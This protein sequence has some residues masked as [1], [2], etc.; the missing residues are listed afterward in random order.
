MVRKSKGQLQNIKKQVKTYLLSSE[1]DNIDD[2]YK[3]FLICIAPEKMHD[4]IAHAAFFLT[5]GATMASEACMLGVP[6]LYIN[7]LQALGNINEQVKTFPLIA[8]QSADGDKILE[9]LYEKLE[10][11]ISNKKKQEIIN[12]IEKT[13]INP[14]AFLIWFIENYPESAKIMKE[15]P[16]YQYNFK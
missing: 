16:D 12:S 3:P 2:F 10:N 11:T 1:S 15:Y 6:Y 7:P 4:V 14:T 5:E 13:T 9:L 8:S